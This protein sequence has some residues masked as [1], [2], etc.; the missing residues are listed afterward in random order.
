MR[1]QRHKGWGCKTWSSTE[2]E[3][4]TK[5]LT[6]PLRR[7]RLSTGGGTAIL[8]AAYIFVAVF[9]FMA[10]NR[11]HYRNSKN[12][13]FFKCKKV[14]RYKFFMNIKYFLNYKYLL[15]SIWS[16]NYIFIRNNQKYNCRWFCMN[17]NHNTHI[18]V[19]FNQKWKYKV[20]KKNLCR[21]KRHF[22]K[23]I[24]C[25]FLFITYLNLNIIS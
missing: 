13:S 21:C 10:M 8:V 1:F 16:L 9:L 7:W 18:I 25:D 4:E 6:C 3:D 23:H 19:S 24:R 22:L 11:T 14:Y 17:I 20:K 5:T 2:A 12:W 15:T